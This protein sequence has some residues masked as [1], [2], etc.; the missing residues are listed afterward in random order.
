MIT[1]P[2]FLKELGELGS[3]FLR[4]ALALAGISL[5][6]FLG[7]PP[8]AT[9]LFVEIQRALLPIGVTV[10][11]LN[12]WAPFVAQFT[13]AFM[14]AFIVAFPYLLF[15]IMRYILPALYEEERSIV[16]SIFY[17]SLILFFAGCTFA[18]F[19]LIPNTFA[20]LY[21]FAGPLGVTPFF[22]LDSFVWTVFNLTILT[23]VAFLIP[24]MMFILSAIGIV[25][26]TF[27]R[28]HW[29][30]AIVAIV[31]FAAVVTPAG[32]AG[33]TMVLLSIPLLLLY[34]L[35]ILLSSRR[36]GR[37]QYQI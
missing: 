32:G 4:F 14:V 21:S 22:S 3:T 15:S 25:P 34:G 36:G 23:G 13:I 6:M 37:A 8:L 7:T 33:V 30:G 28:A 1:R 16:S 35:G 10:V 31:I 5:L 9:R 11:A 12:P 26:A 19:I 20:I 29:R 27:W 17:T 18:Y 2:L 24:I